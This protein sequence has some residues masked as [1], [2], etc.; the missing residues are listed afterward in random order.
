MNSDRVVAK[1][2]MVT[3]IYKDAALYS[4]EKE[5][6]GKGRKTRLIIL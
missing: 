4:Y 1:S 6:K 3:N 2:I 5:K